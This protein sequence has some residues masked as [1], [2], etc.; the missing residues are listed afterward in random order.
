MLLLCVCGQIIGRNESGDR[1]GRAA[2]NRCCPRNPVLFCGGWRWCSCS[3]GWWPQRTGR[4][5]GSDTRT[6]PA[7]GCGG[8][9]ARRR[10]PVAW[11]RSTSTPRSKRACLSLRWGR[12]RAKRSSAAKR[13]RWGCCGCWSCRC[14][15]AGCRTPRLH[16][17]ICRSKNGTAPHPAPQKMLRFHHLIWDFV[18][19][20]VTF[21]LTTG[22]SRSEERTI[23]SRFCTREARKA[24]NVPYNQSNQKCTVSNSS[25]ASQLTSASIAD[26]TRVR[27]SSDTPVYRTFSTAASVIQYAN[28]DFFFYWIWISTAFTTTKNNDG[29]NQFITDLGGLICSVYYQVSKWRRSSLFGYP[30]PPHLILFFYDAHHESSVME[31]IELPSVRLVWPVWSKRNQLFEFRPYLPIEV[32]WEQ[33]AS[34]VDRNDNIIT[35]N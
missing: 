7:P 31:I 4:Q 22:Y 23:V 2:L 26:S 5:S 14:R 10:R 24:R 11:T 33:P 3:S 34:P 18:S 12:R 29:S 27:V 15:V 9:S 20:N 30:V 35:M 16:L 8:W 32:R 1:I 25:I 21:K 6:S 28:L 19:G 17:G 13:C